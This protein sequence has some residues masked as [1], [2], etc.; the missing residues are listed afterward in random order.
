MVI[1]V[2]IFS[3]VNTSLNSISI[4]NLES[5]SCRS[6]FSGCVY[7]VVSC[8]GISL[9]CFRQRQIWDGVNLLENNLFVKGCSNYRKNNALIISLPNCF[10]DLHGLYAR[11][12][13]FDCP[14]FHIVRHIAVTNEFDDLPLAALQLA[15]EGSNGFFLQV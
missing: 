9:P 8:E 1:V 6:Q 4:L 5:G 7:L 14:C 10:N 3:D 2:L 11:F 15:N 13:K 12:H